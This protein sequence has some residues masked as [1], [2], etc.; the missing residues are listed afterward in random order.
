MRF[1][2]RDSARKLVATSLETVLIACPYAC[3]R[4]KSLD[5]RLRWDQSPTQCVRKRTIGQLSDRVVALYKR[6]VY[7]AAPPI[8]GWLP[9]MRAFRQ[10]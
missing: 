3:A 8:R 2:V 1:L 10:A 6:S 4:S 9:C 7:P 5:A